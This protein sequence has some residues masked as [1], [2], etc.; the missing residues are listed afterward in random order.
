MNLESRIN[1]D[2]KQAMLAREKEKLEALRA[3]KSAVL[4]AK[5][6]KAGAE[7]DEQAEIKLL[8]KLV[9]QRKE[10]AAIYREQKRDE[11]AAEEEFQASVIEKYL[12]AMLSESEVA[13][14]IDKI[15][16]AS[17]PVSVKDMG[18]I[19]GEAN[20]E[21]AGRAEGKLVADLVK[22]KLS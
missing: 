12:P 18:R 17:G 4:L 1:E 21:I 8:H 2:I 9:K 3:V 14:I 7:I 20:K 15:I 6:E 19:M 13:A 10:S 11:M 5:T 22:K 16:A